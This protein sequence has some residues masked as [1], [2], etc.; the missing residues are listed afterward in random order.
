MRIKWK[1]IATLIWIFWV[2]QSLCELP[3]YMYIFC[4]IFSIVFFF[5]LICKRLFEYFI[6]SVTFTI[7]LSNFVLSWL[8][9]HLPYKYLKFLFGWMHSSLFKN[10]LSFLSWW[11]VSSLYCWLLIFLRLL[12]INFQLHVHL[13][14]RFWIWYIFFSDE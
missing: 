12:K 1:L 9:F 11:K 5:L 10:F 7:F 4:Q 13:D 3:K 2:L 14:L 6:F 8:W